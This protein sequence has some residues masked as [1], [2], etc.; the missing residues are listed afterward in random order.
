MAICQET[1]RN[2]REMPATSSLTY[3]TGD[4]KHVPAEVRKA[5]SK[6][7]DLGIA[8]PVRKKLS[9]G[10]APVYEMMVQRRRDKR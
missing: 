6:A 10:G 7:Y 9:K 8:N 1:M 3:F 5:V 2:I 4:P